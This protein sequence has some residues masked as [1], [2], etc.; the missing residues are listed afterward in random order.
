[1]YSDNNFI[2]ANN[3]NVIN[4]NNPYRNRN[5]LEDK[6]NPNMILNLNMENEENKL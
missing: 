1:M 6:K 4:V 5:L 3:V 2:K